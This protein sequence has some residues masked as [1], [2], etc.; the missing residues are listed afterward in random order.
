MTECNVS[1]TSLLVTLAVV[2]DYVDMDS[3]LGLAV[4]V[5]QQT[6]NTSSFRATFR[7]RET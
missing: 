6:F 4:S 1:R 5:K 2:S 3:L 7:I